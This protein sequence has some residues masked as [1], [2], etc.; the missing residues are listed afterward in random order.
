MGRACGSKDWSAHFSS[1][2]HSR[3]GP[4]QA[5]LTPA[6][7]SWT[8][9]SLSSHHH[10]ARFSSSI[11]LFYVLGFILGKDFTLGKHSMVQ[12]VI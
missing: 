5:A 3:L 1:A 2:A 9:S 11:F 7:T 10:S 6:L 8:A 12:K 4:E